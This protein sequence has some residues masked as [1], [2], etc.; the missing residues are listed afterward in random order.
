MAERHEAREGRVHGEERDEVCGR[1]RRGLE[2]WARNT[3]LRWED[4]QWEVEGWDA[5]RR[6]RAD[7]HPRREERSLEG[8]CLLGAVPEVE[9]GEGVRV[10]AAA[11]AGK[12]E[13]LRVYIKINLNG[14]QFL[15]G[16]ISS[17]GAEWDRCVG[18]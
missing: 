16:E 3:V 14:I 9:K 2:E 1:V 15:F 17:C 10:G 5:A 7:K 8:R 18:C 11:T 6:G 4:V 12:P 13:R